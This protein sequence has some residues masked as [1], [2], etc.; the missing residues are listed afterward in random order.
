MKEQ[1]SILRIIVEEIKGLKNELQA[2]KEECQSAKEECQS[3]KD[4][5]HRTKQ[6]I[7]DGFATLAIRQTSPSPSCADVARTPPTSRPSNV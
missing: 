4:E 7:A 2:V 6:Q 3:V 1:T 5:L